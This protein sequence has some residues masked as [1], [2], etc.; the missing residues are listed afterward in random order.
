L[1]RADIRTLDPPREFSRCTA[2]GR[3]RQYK[4]M[5]RLFP[6]PDVMELAKALHETYAPDEALHKAYTKAARDCA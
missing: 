2:A 1:D 6:K 4:A 3:R 5:L